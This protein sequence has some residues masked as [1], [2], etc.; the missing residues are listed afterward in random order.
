[1]RKFKMQ[2]V[3]LVRMA[4]CLAVMMSTAQAKFAL[5]VLPTGAIDYGRTL[6]PDASPL[7]YPQKIT[8]E[9][10]N[11][12]NDAVSEWFLTL[13][14]SG[15]F[16]SA[17]Q[18]ALSFPLGRLEWKQSDDNTYTALQTVPAL[19]SSGTDKGVF[20]HAIDFRLTILWSDAAVRDYQSDLIVALTDTP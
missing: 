6:D 9:V 15:D 17:E 2:K 5:A 16:I 18:P 4:L 14:G 7:T 20:S 13:A 19:V 11:K 3:N 12:G 10:T 1:M 8:L